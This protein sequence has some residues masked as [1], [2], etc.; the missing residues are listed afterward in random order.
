M[1]TD[2]DH[3]LSSRWSL[4]ASSVGTTDVFELFTTKNE[5]ARE[6]RFYSRTRFIRLTGAAKYH[7]GEWQ[8]S[9]ALS[10]MLSELQAEVGLFQKL[11]VKTPLVTPRATVTRLG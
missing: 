5:D 9:L 3:E 7:D 6:K 2:V 4:T 1:E 8:A 10:G 11:D